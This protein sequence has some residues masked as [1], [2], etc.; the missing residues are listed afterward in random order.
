M[1]Q[2][3]HALHNYAYYHIGK[4]GLRGGFL[5]RAIQIAA[6]HLAV[7]FHQNFI[8]IRAFLSSHAHFSHAHFGFKIDKRI[9]KT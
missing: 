7:Q 8:R 3:W 5:P 9:I 2:T 6:A 4:F 1:P